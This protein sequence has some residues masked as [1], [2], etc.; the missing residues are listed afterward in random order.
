MVDMVDGYYRIIR[1]VMFNLD[2]AFQRSDSDK[3]RLGKALKNLKDTTEWAE[4][5]L[6]SLKK[7]AEDKKNEELWNS[8]NQSIDITGG[9]HEGAELGLKKHPAPPEKGKRKG[10]D[11]G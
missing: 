2:E 11:N 7:T 9:A 4:K 8:V 1:S 5:M 10:K 3:A 6:L